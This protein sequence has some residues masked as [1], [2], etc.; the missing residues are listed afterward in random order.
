MAEDG[1]FLVPFLRITR[2]GDP[3]EDRKTLGEWKGVI[4]IRIEEVMGQGPDRC[5]ADGI[6][7]FGEHYVESV[8]I[9]A[10]I[11][12]GEWTGPD[13]FDSGTA[14]GLEFHRPQA[15][16]DPLASEYEAPPGETFLRYRYGQVWFTPWEP[17]SYMFSARPGKQ[18]V[19]YVLDVVKQE[20]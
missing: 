2:S 11:Y 17:G 8:D 10:E 15:P 4:R 5:L 19:I 6:T 9:H 12:S 3:G 13:R 18:G 20:N 14:Y 16:I 7:F 1:S